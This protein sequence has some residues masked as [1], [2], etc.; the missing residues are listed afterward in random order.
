MPQPPATDAELAG[1]LR[2]R[3]HRVTSPRL[4]IHRLLRDRGEHLTAEQVRSALAEQLPGTSVPTIYAT[5]E[6]FEQLGLVRR[7]DM[8]PGAAL[9]D[10]RTDRH[11]HAVCRRCGRVE[12]LPGGGSLAAALRRAQDNGFAADHAE[13]V[14]SGLCA[15]CRDAR[16]G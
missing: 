9:Y 8:G 14:V 4:L 3:G 16:S 13:I 11:D 10:P 15:A 1:L 12:D 6:L 5:L 7:L 2:E